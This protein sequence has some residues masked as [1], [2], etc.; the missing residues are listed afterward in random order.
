MAVNSNVVLMKVVLCHMNSY[1]LIKC[2]LE[3]YCTYNMALH[4]KKE[5]MLKGV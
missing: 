4:N 5:A 2:A 3:K 1:D